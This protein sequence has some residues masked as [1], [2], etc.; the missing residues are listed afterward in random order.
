MHDNRVLVSVG[1]MQWALAMGY[2]RIATRGGNRWGEAVST[3]TPVVAGEQQYF[4]CSGFLVSQQS[5]RLLLLG[6]KLLQTMHT[7]LSS[8]MEAGKACSGSKE[9]W[10][11]AY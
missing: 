10:D 1:P 6:C 4:T 5:P 2:R 3:S 8:L 9:V 7:L 11:A